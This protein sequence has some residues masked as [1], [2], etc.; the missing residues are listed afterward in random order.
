MYFNPP[1]TINLPVSL[2]QQRRPG[3]CLVA[4]V[5][6][7]YTYWGIRFSYRRLR[8][9]LKIRSDAGAP[10]YNVTG[11]SQ[12]G[13]GFHFQRRGTLAN[14]YGMLARGWPSI[15]AVQASEFPYWR[16]QPT[17]HAVVIVGMTAD[18][19]LINDPA[20]SDTPSNV[21]YGDFDLAWLEMDEA[22][23][24]IAPA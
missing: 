24:V 17:Q 13:F 4:C 9:S 7:L 2:I 5:A 22:F 14:L 15:V 3:E 12:K 8:A 16:E 10:L 18:S 20:A 23:A 1:S 11:L 6:M 21:P 19:I